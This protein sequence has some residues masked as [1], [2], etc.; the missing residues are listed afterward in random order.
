MFSNSAFAGGYGGAMGKNSLGQIIES[1]PDDG[2]KIIVYDEDP[3]LIQNPKHKI[4]KTLD[5]CPQAL[6]V[7][8]TTNI[9]NRT[10]SFQCS[11]SEKSPLAG[12][13]FNIIISKKIKDICKGN[14]EVYKCVMG[15]KKNVP[16]V[17]VEQPWEC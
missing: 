2:E 12:A 4:Y 9:T 10:P 6:K 1:A 13:T 5:E 15:C 8:S 17:M 7:I 14:A 16:P 3:H 11:K